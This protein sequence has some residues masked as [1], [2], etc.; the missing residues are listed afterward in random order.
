MLKTNLYNFFASGKA[1]TTFR[2]V[3]I[4]SVL[5]ASLMFTVVAGAGTM[6]GTVGS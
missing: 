2:V 3:L 6:P 1:A 4:L 5:I